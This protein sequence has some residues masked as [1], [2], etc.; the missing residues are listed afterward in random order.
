MVAIGENAPVAPD[1]AIDGTG[2]ARADC[3]HAASERLAVLCLDDEVCMI[4]LQGVVDE[5]KARAGA[6]SGEGALDLADDA[7]SAQRGEPLLGAQGHMRR[8]GMTKAL[9]RAVPHVR[10]RP[11]FAARA[12]STA[13]PTAWSR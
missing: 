4:A 2:E 1:G 13:T 9:A 5:P 7:G 6:A 3:H 12:W 8:N 10:I 11:L